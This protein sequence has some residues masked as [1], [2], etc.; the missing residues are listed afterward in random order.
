MDFSEVVRL[1]DDTKRQ[2]ARRDVERLL[3]NPPSCQP[4]WGKNL[5]ELVKWATECKVQAEQEP[6]SKA[7]ERPT[8]KMFQPPHLQDFWSRN[9][10]W[11][12][13]YF[14]NAQKYP[15]LEVIV[16][17]MMQ[18]HMMAVQDYMSIIK[19]HV[20]P[21]SDREK[22]TCLE[23]QDSEEEGATETAGEGAEEEAEEKT[24]EKAENKATEGQETG[25]ELSDADKKILFQDLQN[26]VKQH[27]RLK[28]I[29]DCYWVM[30]HEGALIQDANHMLFMER[31]RAS[32]APSDH[33]QALPSDFPLI[34]PRVHQRAAPIPSSSFPEAQAEEVA[35]DDKWINDRAVDLREIYPLLS[36]EAAKE[37]AK[38]EKVVC[39]HAD[40]L[41]EYEE[42]MG[43]RTF[44]LMAKQMELMGIDE[45]SKLEKLR[46]KAQEMALEL[47]EKETSERE[48][49]LREREERLGL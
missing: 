6:E 45:R 38:C 30:S 44:L 33:D 40:F 32:T 16:R 8:L 42:K 11:V 5:K 47:Q 49:A 27:I 24:E 43:D 12:T 23:E 1:L 2:E 26:V 37:L 18:E 39:E 13:D 10:K 46:L 29:L 31:L 35:E 28:A 15:R 34:S 20:N 21:E 4:P 19:M 14:V 25:D 36:E 22:V 48:K 7:P 9:P 3:N 41:N 17:A